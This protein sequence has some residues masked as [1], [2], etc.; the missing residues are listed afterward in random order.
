MTL[1]V[2]YYSYTVQIYGMKYVSLKIHFLDSHRDLFLD[3]LGTISDEHGECYHQQM[4]LGEK[5]S[6]TVECK[7]A[8]RLLL[9]TCK[10]LH[11]FQSSPTYHKRNVYD[12]ESVFAYLNSAW[13]VILGSYIMPFVPKKFI[14]VRQCN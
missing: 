13:K 1:W 8:H 11:F 2:N 9:D 6:E 4:C 7:N 14:F 5:V 3:N 10:F 12:G